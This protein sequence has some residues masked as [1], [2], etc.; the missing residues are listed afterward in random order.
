MEYHDQP[1]QFISSHY[2]QVKD[3]NV[4]QYEDITTLMFSISQFPLFSMSIVTY[5]TIR[6][7][8]PK[9][10]FFMKQYTEYL[11]FNSPS[12]GFSL[13]TDI[14]CKSP[15]FF[16]LIITGVLLIAHLYSSSEFLE[17]GKEVLHDDDL[18]APYMYLA[19]S[20]L[21]VL[22][23]FAIAFGLLAYKK[24]HY[25][26]N[27][28]ALMISVDIIYLMCYFS[29]FIVLAFIHD[30]LVTTLMY[31]ISLLLFVILV[32]LFFKI[33]KAVDELLSSQHGKLCVRLHAFMLIGLLFSTMYG[34]IL[35]M[36]F[37]IVAITLGSFSDFQSLQ[38]YYFPHW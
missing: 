24:G 2:L 38:H 15:A 30:P 22:T 9:L 8:Y 16:S 26:K 18:Y 17:Y 25:V 1:L 21:P 7:I 31:F 35:F 27:G 28:I 23:L 29:P 3:R 33:M 12:N 6:Y 14:L 20:W 19:C 34:S 4:G 5:L 37:V 36:I 13:H 11:S 32:W 10:C